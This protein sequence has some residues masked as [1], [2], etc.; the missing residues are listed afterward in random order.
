MML[1]LWKLLG[2]FFTRLPNVYFFP[3]PWHSVNKEMENSLQMI[4]FWKYLP[5]TELISPV[6]EK[7]SL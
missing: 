6:N 2:E 1:R 4:L 5:Q 3:I 7:Q